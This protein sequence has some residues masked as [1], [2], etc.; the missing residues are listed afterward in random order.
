MDTEA[1]HCTAVETLCIAVEIIKFVGVE[2]PT[3]VG[4][5]NRYFPQ[6]ATAIPSSIC[7][8]SLQIGME[9]ESSDDKLAAWHQPTQKRMLGILNDSARSKSRD[10]VPARLWR[11]TVR[12]QNPPSNTA[13]CLHR[14]TV[15]VT[16]CL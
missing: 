1:P 4:L 6:I 2:E 11:R 9:G 7:R 14:G 8:I 13:R 12:S 3:M 15:A 16:W 5:W 10:R